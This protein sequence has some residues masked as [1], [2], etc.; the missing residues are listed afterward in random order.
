[1]LEAVGQGR[2]DRPVV[3]G[4]RDHPDR[5]VVPDGAGRDLAD[6]DLRLPGEVGV[7]GQPVADVGGQ[8]GE[9]PVHHFRGTG[10][11]DDLERPGPAGS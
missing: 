2:L 9:H 1:M 4:G 10:W 11:A 3:G 8:R 6:R 7:V 5:T